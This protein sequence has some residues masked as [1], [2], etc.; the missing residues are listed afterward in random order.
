MDSKFKVG[1]V[2]LMYKGCISQVDSTFINM[3]GDRMLN[4]YHSH[5]NGEYSM[6][7]CECERLYRHH[8]S[9]GNFDLLENNKE[10]ETTLKALYA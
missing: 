5:V 2:F 7:C 6:G 10:L 4:L 3:N 1:D 8:E 9:I